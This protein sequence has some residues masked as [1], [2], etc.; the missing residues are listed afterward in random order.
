VE[1]IVE[2][3]AARYPVDPKRVYLVGHSMGAAAAVAT[4][5]RAPGR[6]AAV[7][8]LGGGGR[9]GK[10]RDELASVRFFVG[11]GT[12]DFALRGARSLREALEAAGVASVTYREYEGIEH[13]AVVQAALADVFAWL[14][15]RP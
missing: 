6:Y 12:E 13:L 7:T 3:L 9:V 10:P 15:G 2:A 4:A 14:G 1:E 8:A 11:V 5:A